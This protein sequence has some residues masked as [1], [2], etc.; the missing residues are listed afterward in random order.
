ML[1]MATTLARQTPEMQKRLSAVKVEEEE[2]HRALGQESG[3]LGGDN[4]HSREMFRRRF[5][6]FCYQET[7]GP[8]EALRRLHELCRQWLR[9][10]THTK[11]QI[12]ELLVLE[13]FLTILPGELQAWVRDHR[14][15]NGEEAVTVLED[16][17]RELDEPGAK[18]PA[19]AHEGEE[20]VQE[21]AALGEAQE[22]SGGSRRALQEQHQFN[23][24]EGYP[25]QET[26]MMASTWAIQAHEEQGELL[27]VKVE[28]EVEEEEH[29]YTTTQDQNLQKTSAQSG[30]VFRQYF[31]HFCYQETSGPREALRRLRELCH[32]WLRP[33]T[34][35]K[36]QILEL[37][38]L[39]QFLTILPEELQAWVRE[40][41]PES[42]EEV[43]TVLEDLERELDEP[44]Y[45]ISVHTE[46][47]PLQEMG[48]IGTEQ[49][50]S[51][52]LSSLKAQLKCESPEP[53]A[54]QEQD[55][56]TGNEYKNLTLKQAV[57]EEVEAC[58]TL[59][60][61][62]ETEA[63]Q[64]ARYGKS[65][66]PAEKTEVPSGYS[67][68]ENQPAGNENGVK[69]W[70]ERVPVRMRAR[71]VRCQTPGLWAQQPRAASY[72][73]P[74]PVSRDGD[75]ALP[76]DKRAPQG[77]AIGG[78]RGARRAQTCRGGLRASV[79][80]VTIED[81]RSPVSICALAVVL[82]ASSP[83]IVPGLGGAV[84]R[85][86]GLGQER[87]PALSVENPE[88]LPRGAGSRERALPASPR[89]LTL[90]AAGESGCLPS[91]APR[92]SRG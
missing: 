49:E 43:V 55:V 17:E 75:L 82:R 69:C 21:K 65:S 85:R 64:S 88:V 36:E 71:R 35:T 80:E 45:Q 41:H 67:G 2:G 6:Q 15:V 3:P 24:R 34:H 23:L 79:S 10:E 27:E 30:E 53:E 13:Q 38:V 42:G 74:A 9:P 59:S 86:C 19:H 60:N 33:E 29:K 26:V 51:T 22:L 68:E 58:G 78:P 4:P 31:R 1:K 77:L 61:E 50:S 25:V 89:G 52:L 28:E 84:R 40:Q 46:E 70:E 7:P 62:F 87:G 14:P 54:H 56:E 66:E 73:S 63:S 83:G 37:L 76:S 91:P 81:S 48:P 39:E 90:C 32:Q 18:V 11:E 44:G 47:T 72:L 57:S 92:G 12:L 20:F 16:L 8:R 5:R